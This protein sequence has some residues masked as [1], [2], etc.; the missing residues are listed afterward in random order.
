[1]IL[2]ALPLP[3]GLIV[4]VKPSSGDGVATVRALVVAVK[5]K[6]ARPEPE[7]LRSWLTPVLI[8]SAPADTVE[9]VVAPVMPSIA[10]SRS[11]T[12]RLLPAPV[13]RVTLPDASVVDVVCEVEKVIDLPLTL[14]V[15]V[16]VVARLSELVALTSLV[17]AVIGAG[18]VRLLLTAVPARVA[19]L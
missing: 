7:M 10:V 11:P 19:L 14:I 16:G 18:V 15:P 3:V 5:P 13:P 6:A 12:V 4:S 17:A 8:W 9:A 1:M 2:V